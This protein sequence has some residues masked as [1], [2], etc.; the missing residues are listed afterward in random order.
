MGARLFD[1]ETIEDVLVNVIPLVVLAY[2]ALLFTLFDPWTDPYFL[3]IGLGLLVVPFVA[4]AGVT[5][6][7]GRAISAAD[8][9]HG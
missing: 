5:Y 7:A 4:L 3:G 9:T 8:G 2:F 1:R 6:V